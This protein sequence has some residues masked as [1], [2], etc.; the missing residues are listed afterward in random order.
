VPLT[1]A[2]VTS[3]R[4]A[5]TIIK[6]S[7]Y[8]TALTGAGVSVE[9]GIRPF[10]GPG[11]LWTEKGEPPMDGYKKFEADPRGYWEEMLSPAR[12]SRFGDSFAEAKPNQGHFALA[13][14]EAMN[15]LK[16]L[17]T[18]NIDNL[19]IEAGSKRVFEIHGNRLKLRCI[20][21]NV[22]FQKAGFDLSTLPP[23]CPECG[24]IIKDD[25]VMFGEPIPRDVLDACQIEAERSDCMIVAGTS[26]VVYPAAGLPLIVKERGGKIIEVNPLQ[27]ELSRISDVVVRAPAGETLPVLIRELRL[28]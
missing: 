5:A 21:C 20:D 4:E 15:I 17:V 26:A 19:H 25:V 10:R 3:I 13:E 27:S 7:R 28:P 2:A 23:H 18:Q 6:R 16:S 24:G 14:L 12:R 1:E 8:V 9:S 11:G 22:R